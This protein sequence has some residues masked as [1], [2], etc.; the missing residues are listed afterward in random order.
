MTITELAMYNALRSLEQKIQEIEPEVCEWAE[1]SRAY[2]WNTSCGE[3]FSLWAGTLKENRYNFCPN[4]GKRIKEIPL[5][6]EA[7]E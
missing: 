7:E 6:Q 3:I 1:T 4:C 5:S 2:Y